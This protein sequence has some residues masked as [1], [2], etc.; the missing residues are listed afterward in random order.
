MRA[1]FESLAR[2]RAALIARSTAQRD[3]VATAAAGVQR[4]SAEPLLL[5]AGIAVTLL[6]SSPKLRGWVV[7]AWAVYAFLRQ[8]IK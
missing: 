6:S 5:G 8:L 7:R 4:A 3:E 2:R 1:F